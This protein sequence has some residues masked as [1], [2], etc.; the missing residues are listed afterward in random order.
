MSARPDQRWYLAL[1]SQFASVPYHNGYHHGYYDAAYGQTSKRL[2]ALAPA[3]KWQLG[4]PDHLRG[5]RHRPTSTTFVLRP[6]GQ[7]SAGQ[8]QAGPGADPRRGAGSG[9]RSGTGRPSAHAAVVVIERRC[10]ATGNVG[11]RP[12]AHADTA[13]RWTDFFR[14]S[15]FTRANIEKSGAFRG[16]D[17]RHGGRAALAV[18]AFLRASLASEATL[19]GTRASTGPHDRSVLDWSPRQGEAPP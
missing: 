2:R 15:K 4:V 7:G 14:W 16:P 12:P 1:L 17:L 6:D 10:P 3:A 8:G 9:M 5:P 11:L 18:F 19:D 13:S